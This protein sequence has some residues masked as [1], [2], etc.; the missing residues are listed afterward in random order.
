MRAGVIGLVATL[1]LAGCGDLP[2][3][4]APEN[5]TPPGGPI[6][7]VALLGPRAS[8][9]VTPVE[10]LDAEVAR[11]LADSVAQ[12][13]RKRDI[14]AFTRSGGRASWLLQ[15]AAPTPGQTAWR[16][17]D[18]SGLPAARGAANAEAKA[19]AAQVDTAITTLAPPVP[20]AQ[21]QTVRLAGVQGVPQE[22]A[23]LLTVALRREFRQ[24]GIPVVEGAKDSLVLAG[25]VERTDL[26]PEGEEVRI[27]WT[28][29]QPDGEE[30]GTVNQTNR[31]P[32]GQLDG[33]WPSIVGAVA[34]GAVD[35]LLDIIEAV[36]ATR[37]KGG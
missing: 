36:E 6:D 30:V 11:G 32:K 5:G 1:A 26:G 14:L 4:F 25:R 16:L 20:M 3:P 18:P 35:G 31:M 22:A 19:I 33:R 12:E 24:A 2:R 23:R 21:R 10:G 15:L 8:L 28:L 29:A 9:M 13:L 7:A 27:A 17:V 34:A 37:R